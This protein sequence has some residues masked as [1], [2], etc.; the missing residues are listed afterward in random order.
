M[1]MSGVFVLSYAKNPGDAYLIKKKKCSTSHSCPFNLDFSQ[2]L[3]IYLLSLQLKMSQQ[4]EFRSA[5]D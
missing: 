4:R 1:S 2:F 5:F 3:A